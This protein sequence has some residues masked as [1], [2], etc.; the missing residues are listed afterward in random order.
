MFVFTVEFLKDNV[1]IR[2]AGKAWVSICTH[3][4]KFVVENF[5]D[6]LERN[7]NFEGFMPKIN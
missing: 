2:N 3:F 5:E 4:S 7:N 6:F 1:A